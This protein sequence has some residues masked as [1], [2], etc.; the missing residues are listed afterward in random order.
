MG[1]GAAWWLATWAASLS[2][3]LVRLD[4]FSWWLAHQAAK[5]SLAQPGTLAARWLVHLAVALVLVR[6]SGSGSP[7]LFRNA[8]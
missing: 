3:R 1:L 2:W 5:T 8:L 6:G 4:L 7:V